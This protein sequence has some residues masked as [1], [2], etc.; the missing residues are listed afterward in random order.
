[1]VGSQ[2]RLDG[3]SYECIESNDCNDYT[4]DQMNPESKDT[5]N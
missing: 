3:R 5:Q 4:L 2:G 1:M